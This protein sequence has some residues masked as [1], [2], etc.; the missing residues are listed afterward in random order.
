MEN[1]D[2]SYFTRHSLFA[3]V[4][5]F[6]LGDLFEDFDELKE[7][8][9]SL[10]N[11]D[12]VDDFVDFDRILSGYK[13]HFDLFSS[14]LAESLLKILDDEYVSSE[15][16]LIASVKFSDNITVNLDKLSNFKVGIRKA[17]LFIHK[18]GICILI[19]ICESRNYLDFQEFF[20]FTHLNEAKLVNYSLASSLEDFIDIFK[21]DNDE[22]SFE[23]LISLYSDFIRYIFWSKIRNKNIK[24]IDD[25]YNYVEYNYDHFYRLVYFIPYEKKSIKDFLSSRSYEIYSLLMSEDVDIVRKFAP[26]VVDEVFDNNLSFEE[27][28]AFY[29]EQ[30]LSLT[31]FSPMFIDFLIEKYGDYEETLY[32]YLLEDIVYFEIII[33]WDLVLD[34]VDYLINDILYNKKIFPSSI[35]DIEHNILLMLNEFYGIRTFN[36]QED[37]EFI[38][39]A[40]EKLGIANKY[41]NVREK[42]NLLETV[43][44]MS[45]QESSQI[46]QVYLTIIFGAFTIGQTIL[47]ILAIILNNIISSIILS[48]L[49]ILATI[50]LGLIFIRKWLISKDKISK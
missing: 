48:N 42:L 28:K 39:I 37:E 50:F 10:R 15:K 34:I 38:N 9:F 23:D 1:E 18:T 27:D 44:N 12:I 6:Y 30:D 31:V 13:E 5:A 41:N 11:V 36:S 33:L 40:K 19:I 14:I 20:D 2:S 24:S 25:L 46:Y 3:F 21:L 43:S 49:S 17:F 32:Q 8:I 7:F 22:M 35:A 16:F 47:A 29:V 4:Y 26:Y 45:F